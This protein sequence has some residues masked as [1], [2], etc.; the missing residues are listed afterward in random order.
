MNLR[1]VIERSV[2]ADRTLAR[3]VGQHIDDT[4]KGLRELKDI[5]TK[6]EAAETYQ[7]IGTALGPASFDELNALTDKRLQRAYGPENPW[8]WCQG[9]EE[10]RPHPAV[11]GSQGANAP[12]L[13]TAPSLLVRPKRSSDHHCSLTPTKEQ[14]MKIITAI[15]ATTLAVAAPAQAQ[16][17]TFDA[18]CGSSRTKC[19]VK[20]DGE[21]MTMPGVVIYAEDVVGWNMS[22]NTTQRRYHGWFGAKS[23]YSPNE[24]QRFFIKYMGDDGTREL[25]QV[26]FLNHKPARSFINM[27][28][29][30]SGLESENLRTTITADKR[31]AAQDPGTVTPFEDVTTSPIGLNTG[32]HNLEQEACLQGCR[33]TQ[34]PTQ[35]A[36]LYVSKPTLQ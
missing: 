23:C 36:G 31:V 1:S 6:E 17:E 11:T 30:W 7:L 4:A 3:L 26:A 21:K 14:P 29:L 15:T 22:D 18:L 24:D 19:Q 8:P 5:S 2:E 27:M 35:A 32:A 13:R 16:W 12:E 9:H 28:G 34:S 25:V 33:K 10:S 20:F